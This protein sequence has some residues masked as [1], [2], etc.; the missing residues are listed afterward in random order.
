MHVPDDSDK[1]PADASLEAAFSEAAARA[2]AA[3]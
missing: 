3:V 2:K 1:G